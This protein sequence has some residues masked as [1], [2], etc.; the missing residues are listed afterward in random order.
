MIHGSLHIESLE[1]VSR[2]AN[3][4]C[5]NN[6][7]NTCSKLSSARKGAGQQLEQ[8][9]APLFMGKRPSE[10]KRSVNA[11]QKMA[12]GQTI[13]VRLYTLRLACYLPA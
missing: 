8:L 4:N 5:N 3:T 13:Q 11:F 1:T 2:N 9:N 7:E 6:E 10:E 12:H